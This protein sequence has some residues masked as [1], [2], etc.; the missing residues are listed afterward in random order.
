MEAVV[1]FN[2]GTSVIW[3]PLESFQGA[4]PTSDTVLSLF[5]TPKGEE[6]RAMGKDNDIITLTL[7]SNNK[8]KEVLDSI[9]DSFCFPP[10]ALITIFDSDESIKIN[11][12]IQSWSWTPSSEP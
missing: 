7:S 12:Y 1:Y 9:S 2:D 4:H 11:D 6:G 10:K 3:Y 8:H 5:F